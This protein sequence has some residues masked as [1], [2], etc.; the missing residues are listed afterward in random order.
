MNTL[1]NNDR[2]LGSQTML[3]TISDLVGTLA[4]LYHVSINLI[5]FNKSSQ[6]LY[7]AFTKHLHVAFL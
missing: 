6:Y 5:T 7:A 1:L 2:N 3:N 4:P